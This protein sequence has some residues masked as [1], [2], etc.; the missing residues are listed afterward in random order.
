[1]EEIEKAARRPRFKRSNEK[2]IRERMA[3]EN[4]EGEAKIGLM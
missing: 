3:G 4:G 2:T 1:V